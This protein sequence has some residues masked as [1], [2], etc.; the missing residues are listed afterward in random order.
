MRTSCIFL[1]LII[2]LVILPACRPGKNNY[3]KIS[4]EEYRNKMKAAWLGQMAGVGW[5][6]PTEFH[7]TDAIIPA[8]EVPVWDPEM[9]NQQG[10]DDLYVEMTF[11]ASMDQYGT[12]VSI[13]QAGIDFAN[14]GYMLWA[15]NNAGRENLRYGIVPPASSHP[16]YSNNCD[17]IDYQI[18][19]DYSGIIAPGMP[20]VPIKLGENF[21]RLMNYGDGLYGGQF[22]GGMYSAAFFEN[23]IH[24]ILEAGLA[25]IPA[26][27]HYATCVR[28]VIRWHR[29]NPVSWEKTWALIEEKYHQSNEFQKFAKQQGSWVPI[30]AKLNGA[31][32]VMGLLYGNG[33]MDSTI[34]ISMRGGKD[35][36][37]NPSNA[38]GILATTMGYDRLDNKFKTA[39]DANREF[40]YSQYNFNDLIALSERFAREFVIRNGGRIE[41]GGDGKEYFYIHRDQPVPS[42]FHPSYDPGSCDPDDR[43][44]EEEMK[45]IK[46]YSSRHFIPLFEQSGVKMEVRNCGK[47]VLPEFIEWNNRKKVITTIPFFKGNGVKIYMQEKNAIPENH[48]G[49][50][51]FSVG[52][53]PGEVWKLAVG[54]GGRLVMDTL[55]S[56]Q[57][58]RNGWMNFTFDIS[59]FAGKESI[60]L[61][62][63]ANQAGDLPVINYWAD[64]RLVVE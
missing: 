63:F 23:D 8:N 62:L 61:T 20:N 11:L 3:L 21:G 34:V 36:D 12:D 19:A 43:L 4:A 6:L 41:T 59:D 28:D 56:S 33:N 16:K 64:F 10:N 51:S 48:K 39:L 57:N 37:C 26:E 30:D 27:S 15:A 22:V 29:E 46:V 42:D 40:S 52:H 38:A 18:E 17:D 45:K 58:S 31:Y 47:A 54:K 2:W 1:C 9:I 50:F 53:N 25:T 14:T 7:Y 60:D 35:S 49:Y 32:I 55:V 44:S 24:K 13:L 5:G